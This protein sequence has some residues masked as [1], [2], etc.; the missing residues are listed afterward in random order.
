MNAPAARAKMAE[1]AQIMWII[2]P[3]HV[4]LGIPA[5]IAKLVRNFLY[6]SVVV[7]NGT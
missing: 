4:L 2:T 6:L 3:V 7:K 5:P 1:Y